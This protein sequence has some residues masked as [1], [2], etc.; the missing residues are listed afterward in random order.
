[1]ILHSQQPLSVQD[2]HYIENCRSN[3]ISAPKRS[4]LTYFG[5]LFI[6][7]WGMVYPTMDVSTVFVEHYLYNDYIFLY[8]KTYFSQSPQFNSSLH[9]LGSFGRTHD[10]DKSI[11]SSVNG[12]LIVHLLWWTKKENVLAGTSILSFRSTIVER[13]FILR[14]RTHLEDHNVSAKW[15]VKK[16]S[17]HINL[18]EPGA[19]ENGLHRFRENVRQQQILLNTDSLS[20]VSCVSRQGR[21]SGSAVLN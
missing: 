6:F 19:K 2:F 3:K 8:F 17:L 1:M 5:D 12:F 9:I 20:G 7:Q 14:I 13:R 21:D 15:S 10:A 11:L 18:L 4:Q 16:Q